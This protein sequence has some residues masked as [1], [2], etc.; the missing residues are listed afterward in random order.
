MQSAGGG[1]PASR[2]TP[3][4]PQAQARSWGCAFTQPHGVEPK[5]EPAASEELDEEQRQ[6]QRAVQ[7]GLERAAIPRKRSGLL[8]VAGMKVGCSFPADL[9]TL[10]YRA[11]LVEV[12]E[13]S[14]I[15]GLHSFVARVVKS[16][17]ETVV[18]VLGETI[19]VDEAIG[20][21]KH[22]MGREKLDSH[23]ITIY[24]EP[25]A[26]D[27]PFLFSQLALGLF[28]IGKLPFKVCI[29]TLAEIWP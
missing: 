3:G 21:V 9:A 15:E 2:A 19:D 29:P 26:E 12:P 28:S 17:P 11:V 24:S 8:H 4:S 7:R 20:H 22:L 13:S 5:P 25:V 16:S 10:K 6:A 14:V 18:A 23:R 27:A 1:S